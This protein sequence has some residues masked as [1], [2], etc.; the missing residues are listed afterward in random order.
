MKLNFFFAFLLFST[1]AYPLPPRA[2]ELVI[3]LDKLVPQEENDLSVSVRPWID[4]H[5]DIR[6]G[7]LWEPES[8]PVQ[9][10]I[11][12]E[13]G[14]VNHSAVIGD[15]SESALRYQLSGDLGFA[16]ITFEDRIV[17]VR[18]AD[19]AIFVQ[20]V[21]KEEHRDA[22]LIS[23][24]GRPFVGI[25]SHDSSHQGG[26]SHLTFV[27]LEA[28]QTIY[29]VK[30]G[31][32][33]DHY[34]MIFFRKD[35]RLYLSTYGEPISYG[36]WISTYDLA[37]GGHAIAKK[38][39]D[40][41]LAVSAADEIL[42]FNGRPVL[43]AGFK[44]NPSEY[45]DW[46]ELIDPISLEVVKQ[47]KLDE[48]HLTQIQVVKSA[49]KPQIFAPYGYVEYISPGFKRSHLLLDPVTDAKTKLPRYN[50]AD[51]ASDYDTF[52]KTSQG[53]KL[54]TIP[55]YQSQEGLQAYRIL[56][57]ATG[58]EEFKA[59][60][61]EENG[62]VLHRLTSVGDHLLFRWGDW[63][64]RRGKKHYVVKVGVLY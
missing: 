32:P 37:Q 23:I 34:R 5:N 48:W 30:T 40:R 39:V 4:A 60:L 57:L 10:L 43:V 1:A 53:W 6:L 31:D 38:N 18:L 61:L 58:A 20:R 62:G 59:E 7:V 17:L 2:T 56:N 14:H 49:G 15:A 45:A 64:S 25:V 47:W 8:Q 36:V 16:A 22:E 63:V 51:S 28:M 44:G 54:L 24:E 52:F 26:E 13:Q 50:S 27:S 35:G 41:A 21:A 9:F 55:R 46:I 42:D 12:D 11:Y 29:Q 19:F 33:G 3:Q